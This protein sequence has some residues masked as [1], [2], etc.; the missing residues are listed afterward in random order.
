MTKATMATRK[1]IIT[2]SRIKYK[3]AKKKGKGLILDGVCLATGLS[4]SRIKHLLRGN[5]EVRPKTVEYGKRGRKPKYD[6]PTI[7]LHLLE[8]EFRFNHRQVDLYP[9]LLK[10]FRNYPLSVSCP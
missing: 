10:M 9:F 2:R 4:R 5:I 6:A 1:E 8:T 7:Q 3:R